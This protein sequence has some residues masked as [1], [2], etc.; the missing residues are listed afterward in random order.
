MRRYHRV[1]TSVTDS[2]FDGIDDDE[3]IALGTDP[4]NSDTDG[5]GLND[6]NELLNGTDP[7]NSDTDGDG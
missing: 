1:L 5:D 2:D 6:G 3:E 4:T 7:L